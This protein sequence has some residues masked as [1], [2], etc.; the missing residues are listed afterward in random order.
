MILSMSN[1]SEAGEY[2]D[3]DGEIDRILK[4]FRR[5][6]ESICDNL[7]KESKPNGNH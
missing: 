3:H 4:D 7:R 1:H 2:L 5:A 6:V